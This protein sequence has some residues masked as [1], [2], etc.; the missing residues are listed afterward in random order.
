MSQAPEPHM[1]SVPAL[2]LALNVSVSSPECCVPCSAKTHSRNYRNQSRALVWGEPQQF[3]PLNKKR[4]RRKAAEM[5]GEVK[6]TYHDA[7]ELS[8]PLSPLSHKLPCTGWGAGGPGGEFD[9][10]D[11]FL[12]RLPCARE[13]SGAEDTEMNRLSVSQQTICAVVK[14]LTGKD[15]DQG[16]N[17]SSTSFVLCNLGSA[18]SSCSEMWPIIG[19]TLQVISRHK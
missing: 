17:S 15:R 13:C 10:Q 12:I 2:G 3:W 6:E 5:G 7:E 18:S 16:S 8:S 11:M 9:H 14:T 1:Y 4:M 19:P